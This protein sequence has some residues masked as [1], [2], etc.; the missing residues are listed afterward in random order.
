VAKC[1]ITP[2]G[3]S[4]ASNGTEETVHTPG[5]GQPAV[6]EPEDAAVRPPVLVPWQ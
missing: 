6:P 5:L 3:G 2:D 4:V 1:V